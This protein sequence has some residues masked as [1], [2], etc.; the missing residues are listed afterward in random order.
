[1]LLLQKSEEKTTKGGVGKGKVEGE[2][3]RI[4]FLPAVFIKL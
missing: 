3:M 4:I 2:K 1:M